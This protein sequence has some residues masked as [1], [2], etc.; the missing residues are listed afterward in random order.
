MP[1]SRPGLLGPVSSGQGPAWVECSEP[2]LQRRECSGPITKGDSWKD[3]SDKARRTWLVPPAL[4]G[5]SPRLAGFG[6]QPPWRTLARRSTPNLHPFNPEP[7]LGLP[8]IVSPK[9]LAVTDQAPDPS[10]TAP[11]RVTSA[12]PE[13]V[14][15]QAG[16]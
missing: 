15:T 13:Q 14:S 10:A 2:T 5:D 16:T 8:C 9:F 7:S 6:V 1:V 11:Y 3:L 12:V 4:G